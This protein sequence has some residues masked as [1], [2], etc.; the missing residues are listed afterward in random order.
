MQELQND[1]WIA[2]IQSAR[3]GSTGRFE[4]IVTTCQDEISD[5]VSDDTEYHHFCMSDGEIEGYGGDSSYE[6]FEEAV[7][8][9]LDAERPVLVHC[10]MG[11]SRSGGVVTATLATEN[12]VSFYDMLSTLIDMRPQLR[13]M[14]TNLREHGEQYVEEHS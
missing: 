4:T 2:D 5:N 7:D 11:Q 12:G 3:E 14:D 13:H 6:M 10:H 9:V 8:T 1:I